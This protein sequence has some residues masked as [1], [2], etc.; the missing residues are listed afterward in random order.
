VSSR[1]VAAAETLARARLDGTRLPGLPEA[2]RPRDEAEA[3][4]VQAALHGILGARG[5]GCAPAS[6]CRPAAWSPRAG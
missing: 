5:L 2:L 6:S 3:Y 1:I 4:R